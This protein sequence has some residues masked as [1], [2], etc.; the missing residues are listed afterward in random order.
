MNGALIVTAGNGSILAGAA[1]Y[2]HKLVK[3][4]KVDELRLLR[5]L[6]LYRE[7]A[8]QVSSKVV[9]DEVASDVG[10]LG[11]PEVVELWEAWTKEPSDENATALR[12]RMRE[13]IGRGERALKANSKKGAK[14]F[15]LAAVVILVLAMTG[16]VVWAKAS[17]EGRVARLFRE[18]DI[19]V[20]RDIPDKER[21][22]PSASPPWKQAG[23]GVTDIRP[24]SA[25]GDSTTGSRRPSSHRTP[26]SGSSAPH[27][28]EEDGSEEEGPS[29]KAAVNASNLSLRVNG[30]LRVDLESRVPTLDNQAARTSGIASIDA[31]L[32]TECVAALKVLE[33][34]E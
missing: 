25:P 24:A 32:R 18:S 19:P 29:T 20:I 28:A 16:T 13:E 1:V 21:R 15:V 4:M 11:S 6:P 10:L 31:C 5:R 17:P 23:S 2:G 34:G 3:Q 27:G 14:A 8:K 30:P 12:L 22:S 7:V 33:P 9:D 26:K